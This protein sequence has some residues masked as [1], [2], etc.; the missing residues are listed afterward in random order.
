MEMPPPGWYDDP[1]QTGALLRWWDGTQWTGHTAPLIRASGAASPTQ[2]AAQ[3]PAPAPTPGLTA[4]LRDFPASGAVEDEVSLTQ[5]FDSIPAHNVPGAAVAQR[6][7]MPVARRGENSTQVL[8]GTLLPA[9]ADSPGRARGTGALARLGWRRSAPV[10]T[11]SLPLVER[12]G[13]GGM[14]RRNRVRLMWMVALGTAVAMLITGALVGV[15]GSSP[16]TPTT[17]AAAATQ[18][19]AT[20]RA[21]PS[22]SSTDVPSTTATTGTP[23]SDTASGLSYALLGAPWQPGCP[24]TMNNSVFTWSAGENAV[25]GTVPAAGGA[26][27]YASACS[28]LLGQ[29]YAYTGVA[30]LPQTAMNLVG[31]FDPAYFNGLPHVRSTVENNPLQVSGHPGWIVEFGMTYQTAASQGLAWQS[32]VGAVVV[33]D[34]GT[35]QPPAVMYVTVPNN[36]GTAN[37]GVILASM[38]LTAPAPAG[39]PAAPTPAAPTPPAP[40]PSAPAAA[41]SGAPGPNP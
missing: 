35:G 29:Q 34:R 24:G 18:H 31:A 21:T 11:D 22:P 40:A 4:D 19:P 6:S 20:H 14:L 7:G 39:S 30:D 15:F 1:A 10:S 23:V 26:P 32:Q 5:W 2:Q 8:D 41:G 38:Q 17:P 13:Y 33:V 16:A 25:A 28:G 9:A 27:W 37:V 12:A 36:L 3:T